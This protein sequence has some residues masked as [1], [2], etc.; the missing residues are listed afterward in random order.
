M[1]ES[2]KLSRSAYLVQIPNWRF[3][4]SSL[5]FPGF[6]IYGAARSSESSHP[7]DGRN[8][9][10][11]SK[12]CDWILP[13]SPRERNGPQRSCCVLSVA[14]LGRKNAYWFAFS[15]EHSRSRSKTGTETGTI[16]VN[17]SITCDCVLAGEYSGHPNP[18][19]EI[20][21]RSRR[22][23]TFPISG[24]PVSEDCTKIESVSFSK[25]N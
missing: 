12:Y 7:Y 22:T 15:T 9:R 2:H 8:S 25:N 21:V 19:Q 14:T 23:C 1:F 3:A 17:L 10:C 5:F 24:I 13:D 6:R 20:I 18:S 16:H 4:K 11:R